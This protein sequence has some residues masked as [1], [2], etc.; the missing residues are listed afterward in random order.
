MF[1]AAKTAENVNY[2]ILHG[3]TKI[4]WHDFKTNMKLL[5][6]S[7]FPENSQREEVEFGR[8]LGCSSPSG[9][10]RDVGS[11][12]F[13]GEDVHPPEQGGRLTTTSQ[14]RREKRRRRKTKKT[15]PLASQHQHQQ[16]S[17]RDAGAPFGASSSQTLTI[18]RMSVG[19]LDPNDRQEVPVADTCKVISAFLQSLKFQHHWKVLKDRS[20]RLKIFCV[21]LLFSFYTPPK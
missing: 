3:V 4:V 11:L 13:V 17:D 9:E 2:D 1:R 10:D 8:D 21:I 6:S 16:D 7:N 14:K 20:S 5:Q 18:E 19:L 12:H 15:A